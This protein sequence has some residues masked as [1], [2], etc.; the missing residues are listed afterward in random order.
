MMAMSYSKEDL[1]DAL[2]DAYFTYKVT[3]P[4]ERYTFQ[5]GQPEEGIWYCNNSYCGIEWGDEHKDS[6]YDKTNF[7]AV[8][9]FIMRGLR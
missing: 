6:C 7:E 3:Y 2:R 9:A 5:G 8:E 1:Y 4:E